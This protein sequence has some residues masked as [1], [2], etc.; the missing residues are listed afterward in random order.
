MCWHQSRVLRYVFDIL[1]YFS[2]SAIHHHQ[3][4]T[5]L[6]AIA[7]GKVGQ[8]CGVCELEQLCLMA[9]GKCSS[10]C[11]AANGVL[12]TVHKRQRTCILVAAKNNVGGHHVACCCV[13]NLTQRDIF[14]ANA[15]GW[16]IEW[17]SSTILQSYYRALWNHTNIT[18]E[19]RTLSTL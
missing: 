13:Q 2:M 5:V 7:A 15:L 17:V 9:G 10:A 1:Q 19:R 4:H 18:T 8:C 11:K 3:L 12:Q 6:R 14:K 16:C